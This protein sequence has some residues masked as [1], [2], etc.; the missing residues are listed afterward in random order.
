MIWS[1]PPIPV[2]LG[3]PEE[4]W[5]SLINT[6]FVRKVWTWVSSD[7]EFQCYV[8]L[9]LDVFSKVNTPYMGL[10]IVYNMT[11]VQTYQKPQNQ[12]AFPLDTFRAPKQCP[13]LYF[14]NK[15]L[16]VKVRALRQRMGKKEVAGWPAKQVGVGVK[17]NKCASD[18]DISSRF[19]IGGFL[20]EFFRC[21]RTCLVGMGVGDIHGAN[22]TQSKWYKTNTSKTTQMIQHNT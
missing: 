7:L 13:V 10:N 4:S 11:L 17:M 19:G 9:S 3:D 22:S 8:S 1:F 2:H 18:S 12:V 6:V 15:P 14:E 21:K 16:Y 20:P 5:N